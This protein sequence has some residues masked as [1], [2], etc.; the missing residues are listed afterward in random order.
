MSHAYRAYWRGQLMQWT[1]TA[2]GWLL[3][4]MRTG[5]KSEGKTRDEAWLSLT[6]KQAPAFP[7]YIDPEDAAHYCYA[8]TVAANTVNSKELK[9]ALNQLR[10]ALE[11]CLHEVPAAIGRQ[12]G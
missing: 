11:L 5:E 1:Q 4:N 2:N 10:G 9:K 8:L 7:A 3:V 6:G 12:E